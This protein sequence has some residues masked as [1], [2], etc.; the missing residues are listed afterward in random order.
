MR[1]AWVRDG[2]IGPDGMNGPSIFRRDAEAAGRLALWLMRRPPADWDVDHIAW[3]A[4]WG[5][6]WASLALRDE[7]TEHEHGILR[8]DDRTFPIN[9]ET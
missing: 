3:L 1:L 6:H 5:T 8:Q 9:Y 2:R 4:V 7:F